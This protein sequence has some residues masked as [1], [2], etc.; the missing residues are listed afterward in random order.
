MIYAIILLAISLSIDALGLGI[1]YGMQGIRV[2]KFPKV[3]IC[4]STVIYAFAGLAI[5]KGLLHIFGMNTANMVGVFI[6][7][8]MGLFMI[9][10]SRKS[11]RSIEEKIN[12]ST[13]QQRKLLEI[14]IKSIGI[15]V[16]VI[17]NPVEGDID[18]SGVIDMKEA[19]LLGIAL[20]MD[21][22]AACIGSTMIGVSS[23]LI[24]LFIG[25]VQM[26]FIGGGL[27]I[28]KA[29]ADRKIINEKLISIIP[30]LILISL[31]VIRMVL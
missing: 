5:G 14:A 4:F 24:P 10:K 30:G 3:L 27:C 22:T 8:S 19:I 20:N 18:N 28:G 17:K 25:F 12:N 11:N 29:M 2:P 23:L 6:L 26:L 21:A 31:G 13:E 16:M 7:I 1:S 9:L 15:T